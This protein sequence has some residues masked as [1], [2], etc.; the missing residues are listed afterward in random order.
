MIKLNTRKILNSVTVTCS[1]TVLNSM[2]IEQH[3]LE[4]INWKD[5][6]KTISN[7]L[8]ILYDAKPHYKYLNEHELYNFYLKQK[9]A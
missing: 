5:S 7:P 3:L 6:L 9:S 1:A 4:F 2:N 8:G